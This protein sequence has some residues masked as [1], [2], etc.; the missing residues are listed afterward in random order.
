MP[1]NR[2]DVLR[3]LGLGWLA[4]GPV[5]ALAS[6]D[7]VRGAL[8]GFQRTARF[9]RHYRV[10]ATVTALGIPIF[11]RER[12][13][14]GFAAAETGILGDASGVALQFSAGSWPD[15]AAGLNRF[16]VLRE[17]VISRPGSTTLAF[18]GFV[19][20][21][22]EE[23]LSE[24]KKALKDTDGGAFVTVAWGATQANRVWAK[25]QTREV[26]LSCDWTEGEETLTDLLSESAANRNYDRPA[27]GVA[28]F[29]A[30]MRQA[31]LAGKKF[32]S[33][34][35]HSG[36]LYRLDTKRDAAG[37][38]DG[39]LFGED[40]KKRAEF[41]CWYDAN[42]TTGLPRRIEYKAKSYLRLTFEE[43][44]SGEAQVP[45]LFSRSNASA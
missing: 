17:A 41:R 34:F 14:G 36:K 9:E 40:G 23:S 30:V 29:L 27:Q 42:D 26:P 21:T 13:G 31:G 35:L 18:A 16:G 43:I 28:P 11:R 12:V 32:S 5:F 8:S 37:L 20:S 33:P 25:V 44:G 38:L 7:L 10:D 45:S 3:F 19:T 15:R 22:K 39:S 4:R 6:Q 1:I 2:R 24:A